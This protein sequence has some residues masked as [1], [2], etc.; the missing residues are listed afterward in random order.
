VGSLGLWVEGGNG[1]GS[2]LPLHIIRRQRAT[3]AHGPRDSD[4]T[5]AGAGASTSHSPHGCSYRLFHIMRHVD[6]CVENEQMEEGTSRCGSSGVAEMEV[7]LVCDPGE[8]K[9]HT[10][11]MDP[12]F[13]HL[14]RM[15][16]W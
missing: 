7:G 1:P 11:P 5:D 3:F 9:H 8:A 14:T 12:T 15:H 16:V 6:M 10:S 4:D 13:T 2:W